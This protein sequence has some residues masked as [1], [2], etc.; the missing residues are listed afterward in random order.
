MRNIS[1]PAVGQRGILA[2]ASPFSCSLRCHF[3]VE[4]QDQSFEVPAGSRRARVMPK[5]AI[6]LID[7]EVPGSYQA[8]HLPAS[9]SPLGAIHAT[10]FLALMVPF[11]LDK[12]SAQ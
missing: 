11:R 2:L 5:A 3:T 9:N 6:T 12:G 7:T 4:T 8:Y 1:S 10:G